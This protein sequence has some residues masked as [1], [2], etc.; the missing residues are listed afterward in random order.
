MC[1]FSL[2]ASV[3]KCDF[4]GQGCGEVKCSYCIDGNDFNYMQ[5]K[6]ICLDK[7]SSVFS[8][9]RDHDNYYQAPQQIHTT[10][11]DYLVFV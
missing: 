5:K 9:K 2:H 10:G 11:R 4:C 1:P 8:L 6:S 3:A 7:R